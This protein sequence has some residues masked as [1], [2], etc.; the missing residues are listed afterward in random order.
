MIHEGERYPTLTDALD[1][2]LRCV[3]DND[4]EVFLRNLIWTEPGR[5]FHRQI[6]RLLQ[7]YL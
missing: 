7:R 3:T 2:F 5:E 6:G 1:A 4:F